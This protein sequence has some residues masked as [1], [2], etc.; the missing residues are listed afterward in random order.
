MSTPNIQNQIPMQPVQNYVPL[1]QIPRCIPSPYIQRQIPVYQ[2]VQNNNYIPRYMPLIQQGQVYPVPLPQQAQQVQTGQQGTPGGSVGMV[3]I[4]ING[5]NSTAQGPTAPQS[6]PSCMPYY[7]QQ[8]PANLAVQ[9]IKKETPELNKEPLPA[10]KIENKQEEK[11]PET[12]QEEK[13]PEIKNNKK[14]A[15]EITD[16]YIQ[17]LEMKLNNK[18]KNERAHA[19][20][21]LVNRFKEDETRKDNPGLTNLLNLALQDDSKPI[22]YAAM[23]AIENGYANGNQ[24]TEQRLQ[25]IK[26]NRD[27]FGNAETAESLLIKMAAKNTTAATPIKETTDNTTVPGKKLNL[28]AG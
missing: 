10:T 25:A 1:Q 3:N 27:T 15:I 14:P 9:D 16:A 19:V 4:T 21:E 13:K 22:I 26:N 12:K 2:P 24:I 5:V 6:V 11:K 20:A 23:Q 28:M 17:Q 7:P 18:D 8:P